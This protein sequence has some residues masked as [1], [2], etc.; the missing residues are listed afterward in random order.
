VS[1]TLLGSH[2][3]AGEQFVILSEEVVVAAVLKFSSEDLLSPF[4]ANER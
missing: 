2:L 4:F 1:A 3:I